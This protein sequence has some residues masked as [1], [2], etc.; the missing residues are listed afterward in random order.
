M[1]LLPRTK[2]VILLKGGTV[3]PFIV[4]GG[5]GYVLPSLVIVIVLGILGLSPSGLVI[6]IIPCVAGI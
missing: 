5:Y 4:I 3:I 6:V 2:S 1:L